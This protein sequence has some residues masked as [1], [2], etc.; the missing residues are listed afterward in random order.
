MGERLE[1]KEESQVSHSEYL[2]QWGAERKKKA[3]YLWMKIIDTLIDD[4]GT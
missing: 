2:W 3:H 1:R 4:E